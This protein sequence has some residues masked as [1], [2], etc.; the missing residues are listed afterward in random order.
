MTIK[1]KQFN[2]ITGRTVDPLP[3]TQGRNRMNLNAF[4]S[5]L[6]EIRT[7]NPTGGLNGFESP[8]SMPCMLLS[9]SDA[10]TALAWDKGSE[11]LLVANGTF[12]DVFERRGAYWTRL[13][14]LDFGESVT[15]IS[16]YNRRAVFGTATSATYFNDFRQ[17]NSGQALVVS[18]KP[19]SVLSTTTDLDTNPNWA[20]EI[21][22]SYQVEPRSVGNY[23]GE[24]LNAELAVL[25]GGVV[26]DWYFNLGNDQYEE[27]TS[28]GPDTSVLTTRAGSA[29]FPKDFIV[30][31]EPSEVRIYDVAS[32]VPL[33]W[34]VFVGSAGNMLPTSAG[35]V[36][37]KD[38]EL[39]AG[40]TGFQRVLF[41]KDQAVSHS[42]VSSGDYLG[43]ISQ[44]NGG[45]GYASD[46]SATIV[47][48]AVN[49]VA[50]TV[51][52]SVQTTNFTDDYNDVSTGYWTASNLSVTGTAGSQVLSRTST[53]SNAFVQQGG[54]NTS[55]GSTPRTVTVTASPA[56]NS[57][58]MG[59]RIS[60][61]YPMR[62]DA[63]FDLTAG[64]LIGTFENPGATLISAHI[65][66]SQTVSGAYDCALTGVLPAGAIGGLFG[67]TDNTKSPGLW[68]SP[69]VNPNDMVFHAYQLESSNAPHEIVPSVT[70]PTTGNTPPAKQL[71]NEDL[72]GGEFRTIDT[73]LFIPDWA[74]AT[75]GGV[76]NG[77]D[78]GNVWDIVGFALPPLHIDFVGDEILSNFLLQGETAVYPVPDEDTNVTSF[79]RRY[80]PSQNTT[81]DVGAPRLLNSD[82][83]AAAGGFVAVSDGFAYGHT[84]GL[85]LINEDTDNYFDGAYTHVTTTYNTGPMVNVDGAWANDNSSAPITGPAALP[86]HSGRGNDGAVTGTVTR[87]KFNRCTY[88]VCCDD[89]N[90]VRL[91][92]ST[93]DDL[94]GWYK[95]EGRG[96]N[97]QYF[98]QADQI[99]EIE[100]DGDDY[101]LK[102]GCYAHLMLSGTAVDLGDF[103]DG[104][105]DGFS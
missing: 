43:N 65:V 83:L 30:L 84:D 2:S 72:G 97:W 77:R 98:E 23:V 8:S 15:I 6:R 99:P 95:R 3:N 88:G 69:T 78:D 103:D 90:Y 36:S 102:N 76:S 50:T 75:D 82:S 81:D 73:G 32:G 49:D 31:A 10:V 51:L 14:A 61:T 48:D 104:F 57:G 42:A 37:Y 40:S 1:G 60:Q 64:T 91:T 101:L 11:E 35:S 66:P 41:A 80:Y 55:D 44:R 92:G 56:N 74:V 70:G 46:G 39:Q 96:Q 24:H 94:Q 22:A 54:G 68:E 47:N 52:S 67:P 7:G 21:Q 18:A 85:T 19:A 100:R 62:I 71:I 4:Q 29:N 9:T 89:I 5:G 63:I 13:Y 59:L 105:G 20:K 38:G 34:M 27:I 16:S 33:M 93:G 53:V 26:G 17:I 79:S 87:E 25:F 12:V 58:L 45:L 86:D 28:V